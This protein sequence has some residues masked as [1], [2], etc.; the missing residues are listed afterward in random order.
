MVMGN[1]KG[2][3]SIDTESVPV[4]TKN[5]SFFTKYSPRVGEEPDTNSRGFFNK[6][7]PPGEG[8]PIDTQEQSEFTERDS[9]VSPVGPELH[10]GSRRVRRALK[11]VWP[12]LVLVA[13]VLGILRAEHFR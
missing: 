6:Y 4:D 1:D 2:N 10:H 8:T 3:E 11:F 9:L 5:S 13:M 12:L 7:L